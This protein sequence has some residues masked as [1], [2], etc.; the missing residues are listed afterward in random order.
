MFSVLVV[1]DEPAIAA[2]LEQCVSET[3]WLR[4]AGVAHTKQ[5]AIVL[6]SRE[7]HDLVLL[8]LSLPESPGQR[9]SSTVGFEVWRVLHELE[10]PPYVIVVTADHNVS[11]LEKSDK[12]GAYRYMPKPFAPAAMKAT[13][14]WY[15]DNRRRQLAARPPVG[16]LEFDRWRRPSSLPAG[17]LP[18]NQE[19]IVEV[20]RE[21]G[22]RGLRADE[23]ADRV[24]IPGGGRLDLS[25]AKRYLKNLCDLQVATRYLE[26]GNVGH[27]PYRYKLAPM[28]ELAP[29]D[30]P[31]AP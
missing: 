3:R 2:M 19:P 5:Q 22:D 7:R 20:L 4:L 17:R 12:R 8:D 13:L 18:E 30:P 16:Q 15:A 9:P 1:E 24:R 6:A 14:A 21:A 31:A 29:E 23:V 28:W 10:S 27:P 25:T 26:Y 11:T